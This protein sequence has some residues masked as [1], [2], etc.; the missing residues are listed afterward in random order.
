MYAI[1]SP[2]P[3]LAPSKVVPGYPPELEPIVLKALAKDRNHR[4]ASCDEM[5]RALDGLPPSLRLSSD[6]DVATYVNSLFGDKRAEQRRKI[7]EATAQVEAGALQGI[8]PPNETQSQVTNR[9]SLGSMTNSQ[10]LSGLPTGLYASG[11]KNRWI[12]IAGLGALAI[13][14]GVL[15]NAVTDRSTPE[16]RVV[17]PPVPPPVVSVAPAESAAIAES[18]AIAE[19]AAVVDPSSRKEEPLALDSL[20]RAAESPKSEGSP[21]T[22]SKAS[23]TTSGNTAPPARTAPKDAPAKK[24]SNDFK[25]DAGF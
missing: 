12:G 19:R 15:A 17:A 22:G 2:D 24:K 6:S 8:W 4:F 21:S 18:P 25:M 16:V 7:D 1:C 11:A 23:T 3:V 9:R 10:E 5:L 20:P 14:G 13:S